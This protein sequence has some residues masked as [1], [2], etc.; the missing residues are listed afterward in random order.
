MFWPDD[1]QTRENFVSR[2]TGRRPAVRESREPPDRAM[3][4]RARITLATENHVNHV[5]HGVDVTA[6]PSIAEV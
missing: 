2:W 4:S 5:S 3:P 1:A 6:G